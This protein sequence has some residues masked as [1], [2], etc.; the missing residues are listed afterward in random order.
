MGVSLWLILDLSCCAEP[1]AWRCGQKR[2]FAALVGMQE[3][4]EEREVFFCAAF[5][6]GLR[7]WT[8]KGFPIFRA[9]KGAFVMPTLFWLNEKCAGAAPPRVAA[10]VRSLVV[11]VKVLQQAQL[12]LT[13]A[14]QQTIFS[15]GSCFI[16]LYL[17][18]AAE[19]LEQGLSLWKLRPR[20]HSLS[21]LLLGARTSK[22]N[23][24]FT[25]AFGG[26]SF[27]GHIATMA[28]RCRPFSASRRAT[29]RYLLNLAF[30]FP[31]PDKAAEL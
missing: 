13:P 28:R 1:W 30:L 11:C 12:C 21:H 16:R 31:D 7:G 6:H 29:Q 19:A 14:E 25:A 3:T 8:A 5:L 10:M 2:F 17:H 23:C 4:R 9:H 26:E 20:F 27:V 15:H 18:L 24:R 22:L